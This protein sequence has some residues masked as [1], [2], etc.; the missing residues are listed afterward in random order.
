MQCQVKTDAATAFRDSHT[1]PDGTKRLPEVVFFYARTLLRTLMNEATLEQ[2][3]AFRNTL[4]FR[5]KE[6]KGEHD[7]LKAWTEG[8]ERHIVSGRIS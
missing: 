4:L 1:R 3:P 6:E 5:G 2:D 8:K 7:A